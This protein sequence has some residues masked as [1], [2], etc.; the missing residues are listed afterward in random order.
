MDFEEQSAEW[1]QL[2][3]VQHLVFYIISFFVTSKILH[4]ACAVG[5]VLCR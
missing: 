1:F 3:G 5:F 4:S 2:R